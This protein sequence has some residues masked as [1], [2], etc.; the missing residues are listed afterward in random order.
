MS[1]LDKSLVHRRLAFASIVLFSVLLLATVPALAQKKS[2]STLPSADKVVAAYLKAI[3]D[4]KRIVSIRQASERWTISGGGTGETSYKAPRLL[5]VALSL[6]MEEFEFGVNGST[7]WWRHKNGSVTTLTGRDANDAKLAAILLASRLVDL[8]KSNVLAKTVEQQSVSEPSW[9]VAFSMRNGARVIATFNVASKLLTGLKTDDGRFE[10]HF[11]DYKPEGA[12][13][14]PQRITLGANDGR[15]ITLIKQPG[16][17]NSVLAA[18]S[19]DPPTGSEVIDV[20]AL[21]KEVGQNQHR[22]DERVGEYTYIQKE[23]EREINDKGELKKE[24]VK[25]Y[26]VYPVPG[27]GSVLKLISENGTALSGERME[28][29][30]RQV[31]DELTKAE[32]ERQKEKEKRQR[33]EERKKAEGSARK[34]RDDRDP[35][36]STFLKACE[37]VSPRREQLG[38][39]EAIVFDFRP[40][41]NFKP[42]NREESI[43][44]KLV[45]IVWIDPL[46]KEVMRLEAR[47]AE[48][49]KVGGGLVLSL[50]PGAAFVVEQTRMTDGVW[51]PKFAQANLSYKLFL[52][53]GGDINKTF[54]WSDYKRFNAEAGDY[55][56]DSPKAGESGVTIPTP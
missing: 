7:A 43:I 21:I 23:I 50:R 48:G 19:F 22:L 41:P 2:A 3:G 1:N 14:Q 34:N 49:F 40:R 52:F 47:F 35:S 17:E 51:L 5:K 11:E 20:P 53:G 18:S 12:L 39:R 28:K 44:S 38:G 9:V 13:L 45:G 31:A 54:E 10:I 4:K 29:E 30:Q 16:P 26:E 33:E 37:F 15:F 6:P 42:S 46:D 27:Q 32:R 25:V 24:S 8:K 56:I 36:I 55:K